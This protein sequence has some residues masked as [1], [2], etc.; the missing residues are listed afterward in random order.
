MIRFELQSGWLVAGLA[1]PGWIGRLAGERRRIFEIVLAGFYKLAAVDVVREQ[2]EHALQGRP[3]APPPP[4]DLADE[5]LVVWP[6]RGFEVEIVYDLRAPSLA[7]AVRGADYLGEVIDLAG[8]HAMFG[9]EPLYASVWSTIWQQIARGEAPMSI[10]AGPSLLP[11]AD[12][13]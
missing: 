7:P 12:P 4:Y 10:I 9:R 6:A 2:L 13:S 8:R 1:A 3:E 5:G 11:G